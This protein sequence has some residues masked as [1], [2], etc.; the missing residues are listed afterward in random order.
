MEVV[1]LFVWWGFLLNC[2]LG[3]WE[4]FVQFID[5]VWGFWLSVLLGLCVHVCECV[6][7]SVGVGVFFMSIKEIK[8]VL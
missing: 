7:L 6:W 2:V 4:F 8:I 3:W 1:G 5:D